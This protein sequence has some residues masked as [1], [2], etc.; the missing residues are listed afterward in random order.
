[1]ATKKSNLATKKKVTVKAKTSVNKKIKPAAK[2]TPIKK[3]K[4]AVKKT[5]K[6]ATVKK[7]AKKAI[8][9]KAKTKQIKKK[10]SVVRQINQRRVKKLVTVF[11]LTD[12]QIELC[13][14]GSSNVDLVRDLF[15]EN[16]IKDLNIVNEKEFGEAFAE[17]IS[18]FIGANE[19]EEPEEWKEAYA[20]NQEWGES[21]AQSVNGLLKD[22]NS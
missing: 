16:F 13:F 22:L 6:K 20:I 7:P 11:D 15:E 17:A 18:G 2:K 14:N 1:M 5:I 4:P 10:K 21:M 8:T 3:K 9:L 19:T 12:D